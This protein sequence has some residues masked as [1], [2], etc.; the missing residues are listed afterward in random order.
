MVNGFDMMLLP[1]LQFVLGLVSLTVAGVLLL[2]HWLRSGGE[3]PPRVQSL[4]SG[5]SRWTGV[6]FPERR[7][8]RVAV[9]PTG[10]RPRPPQ[11]SN[12]RRRAPGMRDLT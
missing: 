5:F 8:A 6:E 7:P 1:A 9:P 4:L 10:C 11:T 3:V 12:R 2:R